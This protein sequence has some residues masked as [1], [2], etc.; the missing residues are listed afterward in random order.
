MDDGYIPIIPHP[1]R[2]QD[3]KEKDFI[4]WSDK[5]ILFQGNIESLYGSYGKKV[6]DKL[7]NLLKINLIS[8]IG[9]DIHKKEHLA[10]ERDIKEKLLKILNNEKMVLELTDKNVEKV[11]KNEEIKPYEI[12]QSKRFKLFHR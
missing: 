4:R 5:G 6:Q 8:F 12:I 9:S 3:Y 2:Y 7:E 10:Y 1:E 11:I